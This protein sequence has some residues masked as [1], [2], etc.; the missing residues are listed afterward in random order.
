MRIN[1]Q[2]QTDFKKNNIKQ[3]TPQKFEGVGD[4]LTNALTMCDAYPMVGV[5]VID[6]A[7][8]IVPRTIIDA[9]T[10]RFAAL[11]TFRR[12]SFGLIVNC[13]IPSFIVLGVGKV[14]QS[15]VLGDKF[16]HLNM[17]NVWANQDNI[18]LLSNK[19]KQAGANNISKEARNEAFVKSVLT[20]SKIIFPLLSSLNI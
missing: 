14:L 17:A 3:Q 19:F 8:S 9:Q 18:E 12:E 7:T 16:K 1:T 13:L 20:S 4:A 2:Y 5:S 15:S 6:G 11:E 10:H